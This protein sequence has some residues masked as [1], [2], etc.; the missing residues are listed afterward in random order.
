[1]PVTNT[2]FSTVTC[3]S[4]KK[5]ITYAGVNEQEELSKPENSWVIKTAR[6]V[7]NLVPAPGQQRPQAFLYCGDECEIT[8]AGTGVHNVPEPKKI[9]S[10]VASSASVAQAAAVAA[11]AEKATAAL[12]SG[13]PGIIG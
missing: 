10:G 9:I 7:Q 4:C 1:M 3:D 12:K 13:Q 8:A 11:A 5:T 6:I 2:Q